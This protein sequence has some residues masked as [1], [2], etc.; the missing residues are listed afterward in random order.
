[1]NLFN[2]IFISGGA[3]LIIFMLRCL[4]LRH[5]LLSCFSGVL[6]L[7]AADFVLSFAQ[8]NLPLNFF[9]L[10]CSAVGGIPGVILLTLLDAF[11]K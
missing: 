3:V 7:L 9:T 10:G 4:R 11:L 5:I 8:K 1:M 6:A 2:I